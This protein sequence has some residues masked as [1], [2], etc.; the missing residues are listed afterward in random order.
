LK[1][2]N[3]NKIVWN[4]QIQLYPE[5]NH[6]NYD[7]L[8]TKN[9]YEPSVHNNSFRNNSNDSDDYSSNYSTNYNY[10][11]GANFGGGATGGW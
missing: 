2:N 7:S 9:F 4:T 5:F 11:G 3:Y 1:E 10:S 6:I 8:Y